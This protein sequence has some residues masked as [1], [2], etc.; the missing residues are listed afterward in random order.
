MRLVH[1]VA[2]MIQFATVWSM[3]GAIYNKLFSSTY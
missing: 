1:R 3:S 2:G